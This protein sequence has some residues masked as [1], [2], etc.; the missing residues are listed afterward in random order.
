MSMNMNMNMKMIMNRSMLNMDVDMGMGIGMD[1]DMDSDTVI[2]TYCTYM[3]LDD[4]TCTVRIRSG[5][6]PD[7]DRGP[8]SKNRLDPDPSPFNVSAICS[9]SVV[10]Y[11]YT[12][13]FYLISERYSSFIVSSAQV[14][15]FPHKNR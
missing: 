10:I 7:L 11:F 9:T 5:F 13:I 12:E 3:N 1:T 8:T 2:D 4:D 14:E 6:G 15:R